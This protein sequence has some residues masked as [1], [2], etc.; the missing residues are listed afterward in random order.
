MVL[1]ANNGWQLSYLQG[2]DLIQHLEYVQFIVNKRALPLANDGW[3]M[4]Q[5]PLFYLLEAPWY[6]LLAPHFDTDVV[7]RAMRFLPLLCGLAQIE[8]VYRVARAVFPDHEDLQTI[9]V[10]VGGL[11][12][13]HIYISQVI[14][15]EPLAG[16]LT[17]LTVLLCVLLLVEPA[18]ARTWRF[19]AALGAIWGLALLSK[20]TPL[21]LTPLIITA[22]LSTLVAAERHGDWGSVARASFAASAF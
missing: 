11:L 5:P 16:A 22:I 13:M 4:F 8:I 19:F 6:A 18:R 14:G 1:A 10:L 9:S 3:Q 2:F 17:A 12:P 15:N 20:V 7:V 21:L